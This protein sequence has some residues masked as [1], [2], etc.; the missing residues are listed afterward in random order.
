MA[1]TVTT[2]QTLTDL[3]DILQEEHQALLAGQAGTAGALLKP[4]MEA[5]K[6]FDTLME[7]PA[8][9]RGIPGIQDLMQ[10]IV[11]L[12]SENAALFSAVRNGL[13]AAVTRVSASASTAYVGAYTQSGEKTAFSKAVGGYAKKA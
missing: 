3:L 8:N 1:E 10:R 6:A 13:N 5:M 4:K 2:Q 7:N 11:S 9:L 12:S